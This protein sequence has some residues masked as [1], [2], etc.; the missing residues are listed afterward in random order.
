MRL[1]ISAYKSYVGLFGD[2]EFS[3][4]KKEMQKEDNYFPAPFSF[5]RH[6]RNTPGGE[7]S[8]LTDAGEM[9]CTRHCGSQIAEHLDRSFSVSYLCIAFQKL[10]LN[11]S[12]FLK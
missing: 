12:S 4:G 1:I 3:L 9:L 11:S 10:G 5:L 2:S 8:G 7:E 6:I